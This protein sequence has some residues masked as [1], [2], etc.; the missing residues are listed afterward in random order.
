MPDIDELV[1]RRDQAL[2]EFATL[3]DLR[4]G[5]LALNYRKCGKSRCHCAG[6]D[7][8]GHG[9]SY[10]LNRS[11]RGRTRSIRIRPGEV[12]QT[13][14]LLNEHERFLSIVAEYLEASEALA[15]ARREQAWSADPCGRRSSQA[16]PDAPAS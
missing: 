13:R 3:G 10:V 11:I 6:D 9:P 15:E 12:A 4:P 7:S 2:E 14:A 16:A 8:P 5:R 1:R